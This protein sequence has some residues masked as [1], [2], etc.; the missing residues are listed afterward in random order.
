LRYK[1]VDVRGEIYPWL[2]VPLLFTLYDLSG[3]LQMAGWLD[4]FFVWMWLYDAL[5]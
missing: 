3:I 2:L 5:L 1:P 4:A